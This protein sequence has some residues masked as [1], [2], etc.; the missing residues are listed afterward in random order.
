M[1]GHLQGILSYLDILAE[2]QQRQAD[3]IAGGGFDPRP[4]LQPVEAR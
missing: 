1:N 2:G 4:R 3:Q